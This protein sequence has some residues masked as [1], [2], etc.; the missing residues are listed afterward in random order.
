MASTRKLDA[1]LPF[2]HGFEVR[3]LQAD[4]ISASFISSRP[5]H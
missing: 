4:F 5:L 2:L 1:L 3:V